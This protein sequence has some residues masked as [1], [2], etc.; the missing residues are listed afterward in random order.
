VSSPTDG[1]GCV[2]SLKRERSVIYLTIPTEAQHTTNTTYLHGVTGTVNI[3]RHA[4]LPPSS[5]QTSQSMCSLQS[6]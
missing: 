5:A 3:L 2:I 4:E 6:L 1:V